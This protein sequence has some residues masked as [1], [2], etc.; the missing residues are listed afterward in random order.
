MLTGLL[1]RAV[2]TCNDEDCAVHLCCTGDHVLDIVSVAGAVNVCVV[3]LSGL[4]LNVSGVDRDTSCSLFGRVIDLVI[5]HE[6]DVAVAERQVLGDR[7]GQ[8][9]LAVVD[10]TDRTDINMGF[11]SLKLL[12]CHF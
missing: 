8:R 2:G 6:L 5:S 11:G 3:T 7:C 10:V 1:Q 12:L 4:I 9:G